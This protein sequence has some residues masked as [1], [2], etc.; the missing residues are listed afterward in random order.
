[1]PYMRQSGSDKKKF[2]VLKSQQQDQA[3]PGL[4]SDHKIGH[5]AYMLHWPLRRQSI[6]IKQHLELGALLTTTSLRIKSL[7]E[8]QLKHGTYDTLFLTKIN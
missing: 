5:L 3:D 4:G 6:R 8:M 1:M 7:Y 2:L